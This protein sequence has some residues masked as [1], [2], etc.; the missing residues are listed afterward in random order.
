[1]HMRKGKIFVVFIGEL[2]TASILAEDKA[3][4]VDTDSDAAVK[5]IKC[6]FFA[7]SVK[8]L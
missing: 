2:C 7:G 3:D 6:G 8:V 5:R 1:M 4:D